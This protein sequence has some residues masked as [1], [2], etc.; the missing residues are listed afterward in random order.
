[1]ILRALKAAVKSHL[2]MYQTWETYWRF[3]GHLVNRY[4]LTSCCRSKYSSPELLVLSTNLLASSTAL[5]CLSQSLKV[6]SS[7]VTDYIPLLSSKASAW[8]PTC[9]MG[10]DPSCSLH[11]PF[12][13]SNGISRRSPEVPSPRVLFPLHSL[14]YGAIL[15]H[16]TSRLTSFTDSTN[17]YWISTIYKAHCINL[18]STE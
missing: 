16:Y 17:K 18:W 8:V 5:S 13:R 14:T 10:L 4:H 11:D 1:M 3:T 7:T 6:H 12:L 2:K 9:I 15:V